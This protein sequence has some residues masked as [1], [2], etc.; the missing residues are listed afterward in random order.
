[1]ENPYLQCLR[2]VGA[3]SNK[4]R[5]QQEIEAKLGD[6][7]TIYSGSSFVRL[8]YHHGDVHKL[9]HGDSCINV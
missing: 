6:G 8:Q 3:L 5:P 4:F 9:M 1:M 7:Q 2:Y